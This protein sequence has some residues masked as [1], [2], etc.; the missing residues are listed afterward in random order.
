MST[1]VVPHY[2]IGNQFSDWNSNY[3]IMMKMLRNNMEFLIT[4]RQLWTCP[5][6]IQYANN[7]TLFHRDDIRLDPGS[8]LPCC[9]KSSTR[10]PTQITKFPPNVRQII[11]RYVATVFVCVLCPFGSCA[12]T[13]TAAENAIS[14][15]R[16]RCYDS[17][18]PP[19]RPQTQLSGKVVSFLVHRVHRELSRK[20]NSTAHMRSG[21]GVGTSENDVTPFARIELACLPKQISEWLDSSDVGGPHHSDHA[22]CKLDNTFHLPQRTSLTPSNNNTTISRMNKSRVNIHPTWLP[23][24]RKSCT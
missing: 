20:R 17:P 24:T 8:K 6:H 7:S 2:Q 16:W 18:S 9:G 1:S 13:S 4:T 15:K 12:A 21:F 23:S 5:A 14:T 11:F 3:V 22:C 10:T 19:S